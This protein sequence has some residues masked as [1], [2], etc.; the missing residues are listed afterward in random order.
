MTKYYIYIIYTFDNFNIF[1]FRNYTVIPLKAMSGL[2]A[3]TIN[4]QLI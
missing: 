2:Y 1:F 3:E 4:L